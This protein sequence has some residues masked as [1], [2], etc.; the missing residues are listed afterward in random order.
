MRYE[1]TQEY[2]AGIEKFDSQHK[3]WFELVNQLSEGIED[4]K[5]FVYMKRLRLHTITPKPI[6]RL[7]LITSRPLV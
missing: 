4:H 5:I 2:S 7:F 6:S 3:R 1:W